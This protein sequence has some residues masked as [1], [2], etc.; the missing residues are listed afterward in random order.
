MLLILTQDIMELM[1]DSKSIVGIRTFPSACL[2]DHLLFD[3]ALLLATDRE[4]Q[5]T[6]TKNALVFA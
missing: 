6:F 3:R 1:T 2:C 5:D 4:L